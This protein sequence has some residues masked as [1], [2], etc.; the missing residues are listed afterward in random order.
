MVTLTEQKRMAIIFVKELIQLRDGIL[1]F[2]HAPTLSRRDLK[3]IINH[4]SSAIV[5]LYFICLFV[6]NFCMFCFLS[7]WCI[8]FFF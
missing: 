2:S 1:G 6:F 5:R 8:F 7:F 4:V 3:M